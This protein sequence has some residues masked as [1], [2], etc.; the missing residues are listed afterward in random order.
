[1]SRV[2]RLPPKRRWRK[3]GAG[4]AGVAL[5]E[6]ILS[7][8]KDSVKKTSEGTPVRGNFPDFGRPPGKG[9]PSSFRVSRKPTVSPVAKAATGPPSP[10][11]KIRDSPSPE[12][13]IF[14]KGHEGLI[15]GYVGEAEG[16][17]GASSPELSVRRRGAHRW[18]SDGGNRRFPTHPE[19]AGEL[20][21]LKPDWDGWN[22]QL[23][24]DTCE[25][26]E[27]YVPGSFLPGTAWLDLSQE[28]T[29]RGKSSLKRAAA[30]AVGTQAYSCLA[31]SKSRSTCRRTDVQ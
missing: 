22:P 28:A 23:S 8:P 19:S 29:G 4:G 16:F 12:A 1:M 15:E 18:C 25:A 11:G 13:S 24:P 21:S 31:G 9:S 27:R 26:K 20:A 6:R 3:G 14:Q 2:R 10:H 17:R 7:P 30:S 5:T